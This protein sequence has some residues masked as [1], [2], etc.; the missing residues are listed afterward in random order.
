MIKGEEDGRLVLKVDVPGFSRYSLGGGVTLPLASMVS[1][2]FFGNWNVGTYDLA[3]PEGVL[4]RD[5]R[6]EY[7]ELGFGLTIR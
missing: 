3:S 5:S 2:A 6:H 7:L 1:L 4:E